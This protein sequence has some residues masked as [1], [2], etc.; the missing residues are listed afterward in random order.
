MLA[1]SWEE[2]LPIGIPIRRE[3]PELSLSLSLINSAFDTVAGYQ[4]FNKIFSL[5]VSDSS[6]EHGKQNLMID[7]VEEFPNITFECITDSA[8]VPAFFFKHSGKS[9]HAPVATLADL[10]GE[11]TTD[12]HWFENR[13]EDIKKRMMHDPVSNSG[14]MN[15]P[16]LWVGYIK[17]SVW[18]VLV[19]IFFQLAVQLKNIRFK[20]SLELKN[21]RAGPFV[22]PEFFPCRKEALY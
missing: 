17:S 9:L 20:V 19:F 11:G 6:S 13:T 10:A 4:L 16:A 2:R 8:V 18:S 14:L 21:I 1:K 5:L 3:A 7:T 15:M 22:A 12:E